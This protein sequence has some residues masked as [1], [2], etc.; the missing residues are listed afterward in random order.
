M[1]S[2]MIGGAFGIE[3]SAEG[4]GFS[5]SESENCAWLCSGRAALECI[6]R[7]MPD[8]PARAFVPRYTCDTVLTPFSRL[9]IRVLRYE[10]EDLFAPTN[11]RL[12]E[13]AHPDDLLVLVN[14]FGLSDPTALQAVAC[15]HP[16]P[17]VLDAATALFAPPIP[18]VPTFYSLRKFAGVPDGGIALAPFPLRLPE[19]TDDSSVR[20]RALLQRSLH[21]AVA[22]LPWFE[23]LESELSRLPLL[24]MSPLTRAFIAATDWEKV[25]E[26]R[27]E[28]Y[29]KLHERLRSLNRFTLPPQ[30]PSAPFCYPLLT[31]IPGLRDELI[32]AGIALPFLWEEVI[33][34]TQATEPSNR[35][36][37]SLLPLPLDQRYSAAAILSLL[38]L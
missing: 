8:R 34:C 5:F 6:V 18:G 29:A 19:E 11:L 7:S 23:R 22:S 28:N 4:R 12:P 33:A 20:A 10:T 27:M 31:G 16:G 37:R 32:D 25:A 38:N 21:G 13:P 14:Y 24:R 2:D 26:R 3:L 15:S 35:I 36:A 1:N 9:G 17:C 30:A